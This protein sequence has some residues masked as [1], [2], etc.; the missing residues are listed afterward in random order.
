MEGT[1]GE[2]LRGGAAICRGGSHYAMQGGAQDT[3]AE[4][5]ER[6]ADVADCMTRQGLWARLSARGMTS[7]DITYP[8]VQPPL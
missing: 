2:R 8:D 3:P 1:G 6:V 4:N 7:D 5:R